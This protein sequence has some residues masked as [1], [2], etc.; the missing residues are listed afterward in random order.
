MVGTKQSTLTKVKNNQLK[1]SNLKAEQV[2]EKE[3]NFF[4]SLLK[5]VGIGIFAAAIGALGQSWAGAGLLALGYSEV[6][7][8]TTAVFV[9]SAIEFGTLMGADAIEGQVTPTSTILNL[10][11]FK[12]VFKVFNLNQKMAKALI[13][14]DQLGFFK[15]LK[16]NP[17]EIKTY[18]DIV[19]KLN[20]QK[21]VLN[22]RIYDFTNGVSKEGI[23]SLFSSWNTQKGISAVAKMS[24]KSQG[25]IAQNI[26]ELVAFQNLLF[27]INPSL[28]PR[29][30]KAYYEQAMAFLNLQKV[31]PKD[32]LNDQIF[33]KIV[34]SARTTSGNVSGNMIWAL[35]SLRMTK[36]IENK[37]SNTLIRTM[38]K[39][40]QILMKIDIDRMISSTISKTLNKALNPLK[41]SINNVKKT[42]TKKLDPFIQKLNKS[43]LKKIKKITYENIDQILIPI[44]SSWLLG[45]RVKPLINGT[46]MVDIL[47]KN[48]KYPPR[49]FY[50]NTKELK[51]WVLACESS[52][53]G[54]Y[55]KQNLELGYNLKNSAFLAAFN[56]L[57]SVII[58]FVKEGKKLWQRLKKLKKQIEDFNKISKNFKNTARNTTLNYLENYIL[59]IGFSS[60][61]F[62][63]TFKNF[64]HHR[65]NKKYFND[66]FSNRLRKKSYTLISKI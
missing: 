7:A 35:Y 63:K 5:A 25:F 17:N 51:D 2:S 52:R 60:V 40:N 13:Q 21:I 39:T 48:T 1:L 62:R 58:Q 16:I 6:F 41:N 27:S 44:T 33:A 10:L 66:Y 9:G 4:L 20:G 65:N 46:Y 30:D 8:S 38:R 12:K 22:Q 23:V 37:V 45:Y 43:V 36:E 55:Y 57:P 26:E 3:T 28:F 47:F 49:I 31:K 18:S 50:F 61:F 14:A 19:K 11:I 24:K 32:L 56:F 53:A 64:I 59:A 42:A 29:V 54:E 15:D 34:L